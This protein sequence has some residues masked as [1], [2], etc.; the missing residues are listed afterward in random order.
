M[1]NA[2]QHRVSEYSL[3]GSLL[4]TLG[5]LGSGN[6]Q[7]SSPRGISGRVSNGA[8]S[9]TDIYVVDT[10][11]DRVVMF[12]K[13]GSSGSYSAWN[14]IAIPNSDLYDVSSDPDGN[15]FVADR[16]QGRIHVV[17]W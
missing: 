3:S 7:F 14:A 4:Y 12:T 5:S 15:A 13:G 10:G 11:N 1:A 8:I 16:G 17:G 9:S 2:S 6:G